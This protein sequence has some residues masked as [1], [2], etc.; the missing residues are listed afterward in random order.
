MVKEKIGFQFERK[1][2]A[3]GEAN[4]RNGFETNKQFTLDDQERTAS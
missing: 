2:D 3:S 4:L 1:S